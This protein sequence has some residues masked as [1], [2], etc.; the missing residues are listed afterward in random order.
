M[1]RS[2]IC[3]FSR[4]RC[5]PSNV[6]HIAKS[7]PWGVELATAPTFTRV[8]WCKKTCGP[9]SALNCYL[10]GGE[11]AIAVNNRSCSRTKVIAII[12]LHN[13]D[14][15]Q[16]GVASCLHCQ[17]TKRY[18]MTLGGVFFRHR[19]LQRTGILSHAMRRNRYH[20]SRLTQKLLPSR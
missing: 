3:I 6:N 1:Y 7:S 12:T 14:H 5:I 16:Q 11:P 17:I 20:D 4:L 9:L 15:E 18:R 19:K 10:S 2:I 8:D 13:S